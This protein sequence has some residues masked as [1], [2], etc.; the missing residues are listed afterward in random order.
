V[1]VAAPE[2]QSQNRERAGDG[3]Y[4]ILRIILKAWRRRVYSTPKRE[5]M[6]DEEVGA[7]GGGWGKRIRFF[8]NFHVS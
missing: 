8:A 4:S 7:L 1:Q 3:F 6:G 5:E 2:E